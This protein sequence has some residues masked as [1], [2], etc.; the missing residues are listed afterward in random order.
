M[1]VYAFFYIW[2]LG[3]DAYFHDENVVKRIG[4]KKRDLLF[5]VSC[6]IPLLIIMIFKDYSIGADTLNYIRMYE[7]SATSSI[8]WNNEWG[9]SWL[10]RFFLSLGLPFRGFLAIYS[11]FFVSLLF[12]SIYKYSCDMMISLCGFMAVLFPMTMSGMRQVIC[13]GLFYIAIHLFSSF[14]AELASKRKILIVVFLVITFTIGTSIHSS[15]FFLLPVLIVSAI[16]IPNRLYAI[17]IPTGILISIIG[18]PLVDFIVSFTPYRFYLG[19]HHEREYLVIIR[20][21]FIIVAYFICCKTKLFREERA[22]LE[23][24]SIDNGKAD[25]ILAN[26]LIYNFLFICLS[27]IAILFERVYYYT[28]ISEFVMMSRIPF[29]FREKRLIR[30]AIIALLVLSFFLTVD[31]TGVSIYPYKFA[32]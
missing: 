12:W 3:F 19:S 24:E 31:G 4:S 5:L 1:I 14:L 32:F 28:A 20:S 13:I 25:L 26:L 23:I 7:M 22:I 6:A 15:M 27:N 10:N 8:V 21:L 11:L 18:A 16:K 29:A 2:I 17:I 9:Y 30:Y